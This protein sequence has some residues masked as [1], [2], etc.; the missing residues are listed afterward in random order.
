MIRRLLVVLAAGAAFAGSACG[1]APSST[2]APAS[3]SPPS[4]SSGATGSATGGSSSDLA[5]LQEDADALLEDLFA[6][7]RDADYRAIETM[8]SYAVA[9]RYRN[10]ELLASIDGLDDQLKSTAMASVTVASDLEVLE[11]EGSFVATTG[12]VTVTYEDDDRAEE[13]YTYTDV[14]FELDGDDLLV[15]DWRTEPSTLPASSLFLDTATV[16]PSVVGD[17]TI[18]LEPGYRNPDGDPAFVEYLFTVTNESD[19]AYEVNDV[20]LLTPDNETYG[21]Q[22]GV[23]DTADPR[24][25]APARV[26]FEGPSVPVA[27]G[28]LSVT[29]EDERGDLTLAFIDVPPFLDADGD[30]ER[31]RPIVLDDVAFT[32]SGTIDNGSGSGSG[33]TSG[34]GTEVEE[35][36][37]IT[38]AAAF[39]DSLLAIAESEHDPDDPASAWGIPDAWMA[40]V[41]GLDLVGFQVEASPTKVSGF[42]VT[43]DKAGTREGLPFAVLDASG[44]CA[45]GVILASGGVPAEYRPVDLDGATACRA[46]AVI[47]AVGLG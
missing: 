39:R 24:A 2:S 17:V 41:P 10:Q 40:A 28:T 3:T 12:E 45:G 23:A 38:D 16:E 19:G 7:D 44:R 36:Q 18:T 33:T 46:A 42:A 6:A 13:E 5:A 8:T 34:S 11:P 29:L 31:P 30:P 47:E 43:G 20:E 15:A 14:V 27:G 37:E 1:A 9:N 22:F 21:I 25:T 4:T 35:L 26:G 32:A